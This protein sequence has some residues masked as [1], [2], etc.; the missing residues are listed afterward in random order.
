M[1]KCFFTPASVALVGAS[2]SPEKLGYKILKNLLDG[3]YKGNLYPVNPTAD[4]NILGLKTYKSIPEIPDKPELVIIVIP[5]KYVP[6]SAE[7]CG[8][9]GVKGLIVISAGFKEAGAEGKK[10][11]EELKAIVKKYGMRM[12]GPNCLGVIDA[13]NNLNAS[14]AFEAPPKGKIS[15]I[16]QSGALGTAVLDW[17][18]KENIGLSKFVS[19][20][21]MADVSETDLVEEFGDDPETNVIL[22]YLEGLT[23]GK[24]FIEKAK[25]VSA[26]KPIIMVKSGKT[27]AGSKAVSSHTGSLAGSDSA[28]SAA[29]QQAGVIRAN[30]VQELF[31][32]AVAFA[33]QPVPEGGKTAIVT[34]A[35]GPAVMAVDAIE[36]QGLAPAVLSEN[37]KNSLKSFLSPAANV[38]NPVDVL[39]DALADKYGKALEIVLA[40]KSVDAVISILTPQVITQIPETAEITVQVAGA[41]KKPVLGCFMGG[42]R[43]NEGVDILMKKGI[44]NYPFPERAVSALKGM[45]GYKTWVDKN[46][47]KVINFDADKKTAE[48]II[49]RIKESGRTTAGDIEG[50]Q[51]LSAYGVKT[52]DSFLAKDAG[53]CVKY[54]KKAGG[55]VVMK[56]VSPDILHKTEAGGVKVGLASAE[57]IEQGFKEIIASAKRYKKDAVIEGVQIQ[58]LISGGTEVIVGVKK[59]PQFNHLLMFG[60]GGIYVEL[61]KDVSFRVIPV[62]DVDAQEMIN[63][64]K[65][66]KMLK[67]FRSITERD[68][69]AIKD[70]LL[71]ISQLCRDFPEIEEMDINPLMALEKG[72]GAVAVDARFAFSG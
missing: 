57:E 51:I 26:K 14:F 38:N 7:E 9:K 55:A 12:I 53:E 21:N 2:R 22:L 8:K 5:S 54:F 61:L 27:S 49:S 3:G 16:T 44:P 33:Y 68:T 28:Y 42:K 30:S 62:T 63:G 66:A 36:A 20:G 71:K 11:E 59:D 39:G 52:V 4:E 25:K 70:V 65:T 34:N 10:S 13:V 58:P 29:L 64:I 18:A 24:R 15:F 72:K 1:L 6:Q 47:G 48:G 50:R 37:A 69:E 46:K 40:E 45:L 31:D 35:G 67:G 43:I 23:D 17:A 41:H 32:Y 60:L 56:L 19:F